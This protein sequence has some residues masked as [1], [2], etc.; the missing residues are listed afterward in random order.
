MINVEEN[1]NCCEKECLPKCCKECP[2]CPGCYD[3]NEYRL[4]DLVYAAKYKVC[5]FVEDFICL[6][7][8]G[9]SKEKDPLKEIENIIR[10]VD[11]L[12]QYERKVRCK[13]EVCLCPHEINA[14]IERL[15]SKVNMMCCSSSS[16][17]D[18]IIDESGL[19]DWILSNP[20]CIAFSQWEQCMY[21][22]MPL[23]DLSSSFDGV[24]TDK[25]QFELSIERVNPIQLIYDVRSEVGEFPS[26]VVNAIEQFSAN[27]DLEFTAT[28]E[29]I[30]LQYE[31]LSSEVKSSISSGVFV[32]AVESGLTIDTISEIQKSD[33]AFIGMSEDSEIYID[34]NTK[35][36]LFLRDIKIKSSSAGQSE[37]DLLYKI[38]GK[39]GQEDI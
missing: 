7:E 15:I 32:K 14:I 35:G 33:I 4:R 9:Y 27:L 3:L 39:D 12:D 34:F 23:C 30:S 29:E 37:N 1:I 21:R 6:Q 20:S 2:K 26:A 16:R 19:D 36:Q 24:I 22:V 8:W 10:D 38:F 17:C 11:I 28:K 18:L 13:T 5:K 25:P 31:R